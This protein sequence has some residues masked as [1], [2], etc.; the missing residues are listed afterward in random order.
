MASTEPYRSLSALVVGLGSIGARHLANLQ[1]LGLT[2]LGVVRRRNLPPPRPLDLSRVAVFSDLDQALSAGWDLAFIANPTALHL[3]AALACARAGCHLYLEKPVSHLR[4]GLDELVREVEDRRLVVQVGCQL[5]CDP[6]LMAVRMWLLAG[7][8]GPVIS[9]LAEAG[10]WLPGWHPWEDYRAGYAARADLGGGVLLTTIHDLDYLLW[11]L[12]PLTPLAAVGGVSGALELEVEDQVSALLTT[13]GGAG[14]SLCLDYLQ[15][16]PARR[17][18]LV[19]G[20]GVIAWDYYAGLAQLWREG[21]LKDQKQRPPDWDRNDLFLAVTR[22]FLAAVTQARAPLSPL[23]QGVA[24]L[25]LALALKALLP[26]AASPSF[27]A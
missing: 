15:R 5:R 7:E 22:D 20:R 23:A 21:E 14:V 13:D 24:A 17:L 9:A 27:E 12:G 8:V 11:L 16:P 4:E 10:E 26:G 18:K 19:G 6:G 2:R 3:P 1:A 25:E